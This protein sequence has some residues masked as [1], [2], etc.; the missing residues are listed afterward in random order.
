MQRRDAFTLIELIFVIV[1]MGILAKFGIDL[2]A[3][4]YRNYLATTLNASLQAKSEMAIEIIASRLQYRIK[5]SVI[6]RKEGGDLNDFDALASSNYDDNATILEWIGVD[7]DG[8]RGGGSSGYVL[9][10][11]SGVIDLRH[12]QTTPLQ[13]KSPKTNTTRIDDLVSVLSY[14]KS[15]FNDTALFFIGANSNIKTG[16]GWDGTALRD[17]N[18]SMHPVGRDPNNEDLFI[19][20]N[21]ESGEPNSFDGV[22]VYEFYQL[23]WSAYAVEINK[24]NNDLILHYN[25]QPWRGENYK[26][27]SQSH[28]IMHNVSSFRFKEIGSVIK[29]Q[30]CVKSAII[31]GINDAEGYSLCK[32]KTVF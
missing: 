30:V 2:L 7:M 24:S 26:E 27:D 18:G 23:A 19:P 15:D 11:W 28:I 20:I 12:P 29:L 32:E 13:L 17:Q 31:D 16:Y 4:G 25:Y 3:Q 22:D 9:P 21:G 14:G 6:A 5:P 10:Y 1:I 8:F